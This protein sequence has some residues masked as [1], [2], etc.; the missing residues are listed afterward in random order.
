MVFIPPPIPPTTNRL[1]DRVKRF[2]GERNE[3]EER[4]RQKSYTFHT[5]IFYYN[6]K[7]GL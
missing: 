4:E 3:E 1:N 5:P 2:L 6:K 7:W